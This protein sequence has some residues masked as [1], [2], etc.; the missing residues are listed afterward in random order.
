MQLG[1]VKLTTVECLKHPRDKLNFVLPVQITHSGKVCSIATLIDS[2]STGK[3]VIVPLQRLTSYPFSHCN[4][5]QCPS[6]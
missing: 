5:P 3:F 6:I 4:T 1:Q 2:S